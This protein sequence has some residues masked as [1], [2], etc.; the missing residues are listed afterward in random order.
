MQAMLRHLIRIVIALVVLV[1]VAVPAHAQ[2]KGFII[3]GGLG[4][5]T[6][7][8]DLDTK[9]GVT[10]EFKIG[11]MVGQSIQLYYANRLNWTDSDFGDLAA[12]GVG[13]LGITYQLQNKFRING[14]VGASNTLILLGSDIES[15]YGFGFGAGVGYEFAKHWIVGL[16]GSF[17]RISDENLFNVALTIN[18]L[19]H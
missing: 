11:G 15:E 18:I 7:S 9:I 16:D 6:T 8:G 14:L 2:R 13:G 10:T 4:P 19:S 12:T 3:G 1:V 17:G 5:G